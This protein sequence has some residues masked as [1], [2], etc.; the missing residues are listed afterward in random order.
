LNQRPILTSTRVRVSADLVASRQVGISISVEGDWGGSV[1]EDVRAVASSVAGTFDAFDADEDLAILLRPTPTEDDAPVTLFEPGPSGEYVI[2]ANARGN[3]WAR[4][5]FQFAHE[6]CHV[7]A[8]VRTYRADDFLWFE[9]VLCETASL[10]ALHA[11]SC[12]WA[13]DPPYENWRDYAESLDAYATQHLENHVRQLPAGKSFPVWFEEVLPSLATQPKQRD[14]N[15]TIAAELLPVFERRPDAWRA[16]RTLHQF[17]RP[18]AA[19]I[20]E[21]LTSWQGA[22]GEALAPR[23]DEIAAKLAP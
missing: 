16:V 22:C 21:F 15:T 5:A 7:L 8:D 17:T 11:T 18:A 13:V 10:F 12:R 2:L 6:F 4:L 20:A 14:L 19:S 23:I 1:P 3:R 9:E